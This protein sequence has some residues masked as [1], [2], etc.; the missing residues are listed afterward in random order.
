MRTI[1]SRRKFLSRIERHGTRCRTVGVYRN[2]WTG[3][4]TFHR[5]SKQLLGLGDGQLRDG[6]GQT[7]HVYLVFV[8]HSF[9]VSKL[10]IRCPENEKHGLPM[11]VGEVCR[12]ITQQILRDT[13]TWAI[14]RVKKWG[15]SVEETLRILRLA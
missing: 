15:R 12:S 4:E 5:D 9:L 6:R 11:T 2:R 14:Q 8:A 1:G 13:I 7:R 3:T 10:V